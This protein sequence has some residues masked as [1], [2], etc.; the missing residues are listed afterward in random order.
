M[1]HYA[2][3]HLRPASCPLVSPAGKCSGAEWL[4]ERPEQDVRVSFCSSAR[5]P[6][7]VEEGRVEG[8][9]GAYHMCSD[10]EAVV[11]TRENT[12]SPCRLCIK[13]E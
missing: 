1:L 4:C 8:A 12:P 10:T 3:T 6:D 11:T 7:A 13:R 5:H 2:S 9:T